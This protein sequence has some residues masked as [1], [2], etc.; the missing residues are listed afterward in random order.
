MRP[1]EL[2]CLQ[3]CWCELP[4]ILLRNSIIN[5]WRSSQDLVKNSDSNNNP[6]EE[7]KDIKS[8]G[9]KNTKSDVN[10]ELLEEFDYDTEVRGTELDGKPLTIFICK[11]QSCNKEF[12]RTWN[13]LD[14]AR[15]HR[16]VKPFECEICNR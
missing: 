12:T 2:Q 15:M 14:H 6:C 5:S 10:L 1:I 9:P 3:Y 16:G 11:Y 4:M 13:I 8:R 7:E